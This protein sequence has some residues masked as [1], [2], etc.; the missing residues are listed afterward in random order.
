MSGIDATAYVMRLA[1]KTPAHKLTLL[2]VAARCDQQ[3][4]CFPSRALIAGEALISEERAKT[5][6]RDLRRDGY[7]SART[8]RRENGSNTSNRYYVHGPWDRWNDTGEPFPEI[9]YYLNK[10]DRYA[11]VRDAEFIPRPSAETPKS[12]RGVVSNPPEPQRGGVA[13]NPPRGGAS[14]PPGGL[15]VEPP[16]GVTGAPPVTGHCEPADVNGGPVRP[17]VQEENADGRDTD[18]RTDAE[19][20]RRDKAEARPTAEVSNQSSSDSSELTPGQAFLRRIGRHH[21][22]IGAGLQQGTTLVDQARLVDGLLLSGVT[23]EEIR[24]VLVDRPYPAPT[25]RTQ[26]MAALI[27][28]R[29]RKIVPPPTLYVPA[30]SAAAPSAPSAG[31]K[32]TMVVHRTMLPECPECGLISEGEGELCGACAGWP[33]CEGGCRRRVREG[34]LCRSCSVAVSSAEDQSPEG[35]CEGGCGRPVATAGLCPRCQARAAADRKSRD[36][37]WAA[38]VASAKAAVASEYADAGGPPF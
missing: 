14:N 15:P 22:E 9:E 12:G 10:D 8:R 34:G 13:D 24:A 25:E 36:A 23:Q 37:D 4:S 21:P 35:V 27:A 26:S 20:A 11:T 17:S 29:L 6:L 1:M 38:Q 18:G 33:L 31:T 28:G 19:S 3:Y 5:I 2:A 30:Q 32:A 16:G 7:L